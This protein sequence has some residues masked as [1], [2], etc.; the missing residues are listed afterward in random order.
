MGP[1]LFITGKCVT[2]ALLTK[3]EALTEKGDRGKE[4]AKK[5]GRKNEKSKMSR[6]SEKLRGNRETQNIREAQKQQQ[7]INTGAQHRTP[8]E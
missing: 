1:E 3:W 2:A 7:G 4:R 8:V 6:E 5:V